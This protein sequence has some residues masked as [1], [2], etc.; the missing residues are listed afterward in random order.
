M[1]RESRNIL[2]DLW[3]QIWETGAWIL[4]LNCCIVVSWLNM[5][6]MTRSLG[7]GKEKSVGLL[8]A[9]DI[10]PG[11]V[12]IAVTA[13]ALYI[14]NK[15]KNRF[16]FRLPVPGGPDPV[17]ASPDK[18]RAMHQPIAPEYRSDLPKSFTIGKDG[19]HYVTLPEDK[20]NIFHCLI[21]GAPG[22]WKS[23]TIL[24][25]LIWNFNY[26]SPEE[27]M[28]V[29]ALDVKPELLRKSVFYDQDID[30]AKLKVKVINPT[31]S[32][33]YYY[34]FD[35]YFGLS[36][37][38]TDDELEDRMD[39]IAR[40]LIATSDESENAIFYHTAQNIMI[41]ILIYGFRKG[42][43]F[44]DSMH[45]L[46]SVSVKDMI[47]EI[48]SDKEMVK[49]H[50]KLRMI[51][52]THDGDGSEMLQD[53]ENTMHEMLRIF[54]ND[55]VKYCLQDNPRMASP[56]DLTN[57]ISVFLS[58][59]D[60]ELH[61]FSPIFRMITQLVINYLGSIPDRKRSEPD[62]P[63]IW[64]LIDEFGSIGHLDIAEPLARFRSRKI[65]IWLC[66]Q[67]LSQLDQTY[68]KDGRRSIMTN[69]KVKLVLSSTDD[70][71]DK[72]YAALAGNYRETKVANNR[73]GVLGITNNSTQNLS[74]EYRP[75]FDIADLR[76]LEEE[77]KILAYVNGSYIYA[78]KCPYFLIP[79]LRKTSE[80]IVEA[81]D[82]EMDREGVE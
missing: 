62:V 74:T 41:G 52:Q 64:L 45:M 55:S 56:E 51:L 48:L 72:M 79:T 19:R 80:R 65:S 8:T 13:A 6:T 11:V 57:G 53:A 76:R 7:T 37:D 70:E 15:Y 31:S 35:P 17:S 39:T 33:P 36:Q 21:V 77:K 67:G 69:C 54:S 63:I 20:N 66:A 23:A 14:Y 43:G 46:M 16:L 58:I 49:Q 34:G 78:D 73:N 30:N 10:M 28:T 60:S 44:I 12:L 82:K 40:S 27:R 81:N 18:V 26:A 61:R 25:S 9:S 4:V 24:N 38:N 68:G 71:A 3:H 59:P 5:L 47:A 2:T 42:L 50:P 32:N 29:F 1:K 75:I 22:A